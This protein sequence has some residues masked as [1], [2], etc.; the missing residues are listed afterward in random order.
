MNGHNVFAGAFVDRSGHRR[1]DTAWLKSA[2]AAENTV[3]VPVWGDKCL[4]SGEPLHAVLLPRRDV[5]PWLREPDAIF[6]GM[7]RDRPAF[8]VSI[9]AKDE[10]PFGDI[11]QF[12]DLRYLGNALPVDEANLVAQARALVVWHQSQRFCG[13]CGALSRAESGGNTRV[14]I[15]PECGIRIFPRVDPAIIVLVTDRDRCLLGRQGNW[16][17]GRYSTIAGFVEPGESLEDAVQ[18]EVLEET[19]IS[20]H[21]IRYHSSQPWP[22]PSSLMLGF[23]ADALTDEIALNDGELTDAKWF[24]VKELKSGY[25]LLPYRLSIARRLVDDWVEEHDHPAQRRG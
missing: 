13:R 3:F 4:A 16:P 14:C 19:N 15:G 11:G 17:E 2:L 23:I 18:R 21:N 5:E 24:T 25:P 20:V 7:Y 9:D 6:L 8:A 10:P 22:F 12:H 1:E